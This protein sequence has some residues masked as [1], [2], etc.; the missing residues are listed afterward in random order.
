MPEATERALRAVVTVDAGCTIRIAFPNG[1]RS[2]MS[3]PY[4]RSTG[5]WVNSTPFAFSSS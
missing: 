1:S 4:Q 5:S 2:P 3:V